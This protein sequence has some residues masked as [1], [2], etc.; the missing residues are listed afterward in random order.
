[1]VSLGTTR[2]W[3]FYMIAFTVLKLSKGFS[4]STY[5]NIDNRVFI[6]TWKIKYGS[7]FTNQLM[8]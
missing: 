4:S 3:D 8:G 6:K 7:L 2:V 1:V 5:Y